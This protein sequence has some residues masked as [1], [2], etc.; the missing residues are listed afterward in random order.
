MELI[1]GEPTLHPHLVDFFE[2]ASLI[3][4][5]QLAVLTNLSFPIEYY[6]N[7]IDKHRV[8]IIPTWHSLPHDPANS[9]FLEKIMSVPDK[10]FD[11]VADG[12]HW[13]NFFIRIMFEKDHFEEAKRVYLALA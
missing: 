1:G 12:K 7:L 2:K 9:K 6:L 5:I 3:P 13:H 11:F 8:R 10:Y 4:D